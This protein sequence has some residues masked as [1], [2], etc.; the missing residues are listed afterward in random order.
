MRC[1]RVVLLLLLPSVCLTQNISADNGVF[2]AFRQFAGLSLD[3]V[4]H[5]ENVSDQCRIE[6]DML[7]RG[8]Q[9]TQ[10]WALKSKSL[11]P[12]KYFL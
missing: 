8:V 4:P 3:F 2:D 10:L 6:S 1:Y 11:L 5:G 7:R 9:D 12:R